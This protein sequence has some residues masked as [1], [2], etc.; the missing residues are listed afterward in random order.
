MPSLATRAPSAPPS[1]VEVERMLSW[2]SAFAASITLARAGVVSSAPA[3]ASGQS[4]TA[5]HS[6]AYLTSILEP[7]H[8]AALRRPPIPLILPSAWARNPSSFLGRRTFALE[9]RAVS[10]GAV[11]I[12]PLLVREVEILERADLVG[13]HQP[14]LVDEPP[15]AGARRA[16]ALGQSR[17]PALAEIIE[18][19]PDE[20]HR[21]GGGEG[22]IE[23]DLHAELLIFLRRRGGAVAAPDGEHRPRNIA[24][25]DLDLLARLG[26]VQPD[27]IDAALLDIGGAALHRILE[28]AA[29]GAQ[30][31]AAGADHEARIDLVARRDGRLI[32]ADRLLERDRA[33]AGDRAGFLRRLLVLDLQRRDAGAHDLLHGVMDIHRI[34]V[35]GVR[36]D[37]DRNIGARRHM[38]RVIDEVAQ[39]DDAIVGIAVE[40]HRQLRAG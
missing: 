27:E 12:A 14:L 32:F 13:A 40:H 18:E 9:G 19:L 29:F 35:A 15:F 26:G 4:R 20:L 30:H 21:E 22:R 3:P 39:A 11:V 6:A 10:P 34:A 25:G 1:T 5:A 36:I 7:S 31:V 28:A 24:A 2:P 8:G 17:R 16:R 33:A 23:R 38:A 37:E